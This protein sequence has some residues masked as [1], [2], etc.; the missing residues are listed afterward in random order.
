MIS[1]NVKV[2]RRRL[3]IGWF[4]VALVTLIASFWAYWGGIENF[5]EGWYYTGLWDNILLMLAQYW[6]FALA[7][8]SIGLIGIRFP[9]ITLAVCAVMGIAACIFFTNAH[10]SVIWLLIIIPF[11]GIGLLYFFWATQAKMARND[12]N[13]RIA[14]IDFA[15]NHHHRRC[16][17]LATPG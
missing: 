4:A 16:Q 9:K 6:L 8:M 15:D 13:D 11:V 12:H 2:V 1:Q 5:H 7:F 10:F 3:Y 17:G 14:C